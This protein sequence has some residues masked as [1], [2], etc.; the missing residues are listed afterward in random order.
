MAKLTINGNTIKVKKGTTI[1]NAANSIGVEIPTLCYIAEM[2]EIGFCRMCVVEVE[3]EQDLV[4]A[5]NTEITNKMVVYTNSVKVQEARK[6]TLRLLAN[7]HRFDCWNCPKD[8]MCEFYDLLKE[9]DIVFEEFGPGKGRYPDFIDGSAINQDQTKCVLCKRCVAVCNEVVEARVL[10]FRDDDGLNPIVSPTPELSFDASGCIGCGQ[11]V[12][13]CP[14]GTLF[15]AD[16]QTRV[17][18]KLLESNTPV[19]AQ[20]SEEA[21]HII[22]EELSQFGDE[23]GIRDA[24]GVIKQLGFTDVLD[25]NTAKDVLVLEE[26]NTLKQH[27]NNQQDVSL[28]SSHCPAAVRFTELYNDDYISELSTSKTA[29]MMQAKLIKDVLETPAYVVSILPCTSAK[30]E[31]ER[32]ELKDHVDAVLTVN[33]VMKMI[34]HRYLDKDRKDVDIEGGTLQ[35]ALSVATNYQGSMVQLENVLNTL[36]LE[37]DNKPLDPIEYKVIAGDE[38]KA[39]TGVIKEAKVKIGDY[40]LRVAVVRGGAQIKAFYKLL[41]N[42]KTTYDYVDMMACPEGCANGG[43]TPF[44]HDITTHDV[45]KKRIEL[46]CQSTDMAQYDPNISTQTLYQKYLDQPSSDQMIALLHTSFSPKESTKE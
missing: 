35:A 32:D 16:H 13:A 21:A 19:I 29:H 28:I 46:L 8:G 38:S 31:M 43:G 42:S 36:S 3:G 18:D 40:K 12:K 33:E 10:K 39:S 27:L 20:I 5:C 22:A 41:D 1:L 34:K 30:M 14:T 45:I 9:H 6:A 2:N 24:Y 44:I 23:L 17:E 15:E 11:C 7:K 37:I 26:V 25:I 4:S